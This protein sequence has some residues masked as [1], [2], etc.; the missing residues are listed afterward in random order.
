LKK[1]KKKEVEEESIEI[2]FNVLAVPKLIGI[3]PG[4]GL[5][6]K[7]DNLDYKVSNVRYS[8]TG[9]YFSCNV[10]ATRAIDEEPMFPKSINKMRSKMDFLG[11]EE[12]EWAKYYWG[13]N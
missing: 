1:Q 9:K 2:S 12:R 6:L 10:S 4:D 7:E 3:T 11:E 8:Q 5:L 13:K